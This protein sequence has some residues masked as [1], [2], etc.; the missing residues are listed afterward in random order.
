MYLDGLGVD[1]NYREAAEFLML[2]AKQGNKNAVETLESEDTKNRLSTFYN[3]SR[4]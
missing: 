4:Q 1:I 3:I 2:A